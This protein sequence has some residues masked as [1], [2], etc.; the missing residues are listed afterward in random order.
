MEI[1]IVTSLFAGFMAFHRGAARYLFALSRDGLTFRALGRI[2]RR[3]GTPHVAQAVQLAI[4]IVVVG[5]LAALG[6][7]PYLQIAAPILAL[8]TIG[9]VAMQGAASV[10]IV[11]F[12]R[13]R[14]DERLWGTLI[15]PQ[16]S[17]AGLI[18][19]AVLAV[20]NFGTLVGS[21]SGLI[22]LLPWLYV[23]AVTIG[24]AA[25]ARERARRPQHHA[26]PSGGPSRSGAAP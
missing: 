6:R 16:L 8:G 1:L 3:H 23:V 17:S 12:F 10:S 4:V 13:R 24:L 19:S 11:V 25:L 15:A 21:S 9:I 5:G 2:H 20:T 26:S 7:D 14:A 22:G 18:A